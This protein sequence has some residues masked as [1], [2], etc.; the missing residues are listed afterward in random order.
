MAHRI[1]TPE[2]AGARDQARSL[3]AALGPDLVDED[4]ILDCTNLLVGTPSFL[5]E[6]VKQILVQRGA[7]TLSVV[8]PSDRVHLLLERAAENRGARD[9]LEFAA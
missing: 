5:D 9:R 4:V 8:M 2:H 1:V 7:R 3:A 6:I